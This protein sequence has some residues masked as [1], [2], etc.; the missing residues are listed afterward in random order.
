MMKGSE[1]ANDVVVLKDDSGAYY[2]LTR[3]A[4]ALFKVAPGDPADRIETV[5]TA[6]PAER[7]LSALGLKVVG[8][9]DRSSNSSIKREFVEPLLEVLGP[10]HPSGNP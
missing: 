10:D 3:E 9:F 1:M 8:S 5:M 7:S 4:L 6:G 2:T